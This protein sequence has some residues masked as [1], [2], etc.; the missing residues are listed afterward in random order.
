MASVALDGGALA[1]WI[2]AGWTSVIAPH[3][4][5]A[6]PNTL[7]LQF[8]DFDVAITYVQQG[9]ETANGVGRP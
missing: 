5:A 9:D 1:E 7:W 8:S 4:S 2:L 6:Q 3:L